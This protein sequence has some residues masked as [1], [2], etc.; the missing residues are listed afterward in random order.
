VIDVRSSA[1]AW[2]EANTHSHREY[3]IPDLLAAKH[4]TSTS[5]SVVIP[6]RNEATTIAAIIRAVRD[7]LVEGC[8][9]VDE[10]LVVDSLS[11]DATAEVARDAGA[12]VVHV[13]E[14]APQLPAAAGKGEALWRS[15]FVTHGEVL[16]FIDADL[17]YW[18]THFVTGLLGPVLTSS[19]TLL[20]K[21]FYDRTVD[22]GPAEAGHRPQGGRVTELMARPL[23][24]QIWPDL[25]AVV[26]PLAGEW[27]VRRGLLETLT[28]PVGYGIEFAVLVDTYLRLGLDV[29]SQ[30]DLGA[31]Q[32]QHQSVHD[33][34]VMAAEILA[35]ARRR[36]DG[37]EPAERTLAQYRRDNGSGSWDERAV[38]VAERPPAVELAAYR[39]RSAT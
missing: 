36:A 33:L 6:A 1:R 29:M 26:Q 4:R 9:L 12:R 8:G 19:D 20:V 30:V 11:E 27:A 10:L 22:G 34:G 2:F 13:G 31:R 25:A 35:V 3:L 39:H 37:V 28:V 5:V 24:A 7:E 23:L 32:H 38:P 21:G 15:L 17:T 16:V 14:V 18:G